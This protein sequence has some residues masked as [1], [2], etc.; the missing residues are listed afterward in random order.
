MKHLTSFSK[1]ASGVSQDLKYAAKGL[2]KHPRFAA[3]AVVTLALGIGASTLIFSAVNGILLRPLPYKDADRL[4]RIH[5]NFPLLKMENI[6]VRPREFRD[7]RDMNQAFDDLAAFTVADFNITGAGQPEKVRGAFVT[8]GLFALLGCHPSAGR[9]FDADEFSPGRDNIAV[10]SDALWAD[11]Y[12]RS[13]DA[14]GSPI[15]LNGTTYNIVGIMQAGFEFRHL[16]RDRSEP[17][18]VWLPLD[19]TQ[20]ELQ[21]GGWFLDVI[22]RLKHGVS[23]EQARGDI[24][25]IA[26][27]FVGRYREYKGPHGE[28][29]GWRASLFTVKDEEVGKVGAS[30]VALMAA[31]GFLL[32]IACANV[33]NLV[34]VRGTGREREIAIRSALGAGAARIFRQ[35]LLENF[36]IALLGSGVGLLLVYWGRDLLITAGS[37]SI[38][39]IDEVNLDL[40][41]LGFCATLAILTPMLFG[42]APTVKLSSSNLIDGLRQTARRRRLGRGRG[43]LVAVEAGMSVVLLIS[44]GLLIRSFIGLQR[45]DLGMNPDNVMTARLDLPDSKYHDAARQAGFFQDLFSRLTAVPNV[46]SSSLFTSAVQDPFSVEGKPFDPSN[47]STALHLLVAPRYFET[48][49]IPLLSGREFTSSDVIGSPGVAI[50]NRALARQFFAD[51]NAIGHHIKVGAP[52]SGRWLTIVGVV[53]DSRDEGPAAAPSPTLYIAYQQSPFPSATLALRYRGDM[54]QAVSLLR[55]GIAEIDK[56]Q[57]SYH[58]EPL[59]RRLAR[60]VAEPRLDALLMSA[61]SLT[62]LLLAIIG[63]YVVMSYSV[64]QRMKEI[65]IRMALGARGLDVARLMI[66]GG[67]VWTCGG[68]IAG[69]VGSY[70]ATRL[71]SG[72]LFNVSASDIW[73]FVTVPSLLFATALLACLIPAIR[74]SRLD[75]VTVLRRE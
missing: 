52:G 8:D 67:M 64:A 4:V 30:L 18:D 34:L 2:I 29:G 60:S 42:L 15:A 37:K 65:G 59:T 33:A 53:G 17:V 47:P 16:L 9:M 3:M 62:A 41:V 32:L 25:L 5:G 6:G 44:A 21:S 68:I 7:Y 27:G 63:V 69:L 57:P 19:F 36:F 1:A 61:F 10:I 23:L 31:V 71:I 14:L 26:N 75:P 54:D 13:R 72:L 40:R 20:E 56:D 11:R 46:Q 50:I 39:R 66:R 24:G 38:P 70:F 45:V 74:A 12:S 43:L 48:L 28:D 51:Q 22:G 73:T 58:I 55:R 49:Q 35:L